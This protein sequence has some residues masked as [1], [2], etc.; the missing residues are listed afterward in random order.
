MISYAIR[1]NNIMKL[2][3]YIFK[4]MLTLLTSVIIIAQ[5]I[6]VLPYAPNAYSMNII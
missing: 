6:T 3:L 1:I 5:P 2:I 4:I